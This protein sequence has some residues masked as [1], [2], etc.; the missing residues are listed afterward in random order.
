MGRVVSSDDKFQAVIKA[1][2]GR[3][4]WNRGGVKGHLHAHLS[5]LWDG[6]DWD[7]ETKTVGLASNSQQR[8]MVWAVNKPA[9]GS[10]WAWKAKRHESYSMLFM[11]T[12]I[13]NT[14]D[15]ASPPE[16]HGL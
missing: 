4:H 8:R 6:R 16:V 7:R 13:L 15:T 12:W 11:R 2:G 14:E 5:H 10:M 9:T 1:V 3:S